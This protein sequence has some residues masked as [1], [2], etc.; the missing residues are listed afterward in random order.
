MNV[1]RLIKSGSTF[2]PVFPPYVFNVQSE[3]DREYMYFYAFRAFRLVVRMI[4]V[5]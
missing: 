5:N 3:S 2:L 4:N 1:S